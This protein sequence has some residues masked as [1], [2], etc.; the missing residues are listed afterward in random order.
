MPWDLIYNPLVRPLVFFFLLIAMSI[1][2]ILP[3]GPA[4]AGP[5]IVFDSES[6]DFGFVAA[7][8]SVEHEFFFRNEGT[9]PLIIERV[10]GG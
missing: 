10:S 1:A 5:S 3:A 2:A 6:H 7:G 4:C 9:E 8:T